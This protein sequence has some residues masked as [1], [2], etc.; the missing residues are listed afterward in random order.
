VGVDDPLACGLVE[1]GT[2]RQAGRIGSRGRRLGHGEAG[3]DRALEERLEPLR[4]LLVGPVIDEDLDVAGVGRRAVEDEGRD[5]AAPHHL[6]EHPVLPVGQPGAVLIRE[7]QVPEALG[8]R[9]V[10]Q[11][12]Q[13]LRVGNARP[14]LGVEG[15]QRLHLYGVDVLVEERLDA[16]GQLGDSVGG[17]EVHGRSVTGASSGRP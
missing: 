13:D 17:C 11:V 1:L 2:A 7:E 3:A 14:D 8:L 12:G 4:L 10:A 16:A 9:A 15:V 5:H 6:A